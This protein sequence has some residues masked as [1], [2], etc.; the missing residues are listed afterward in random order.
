MFIFKYFF[1]FLDTTRE[2]AK[3]TQNTKIIVGKLVTLKGQMIDQI[4]GY[5]KGVINLTLHKEK[6]SLFTRNNNDILNEKR[7]VEEEV[8]TA[9]VL[10]DRVVQILSKYEADRSS[11]EQEA[12][13]LSKGKH[14]SDKN[15][16]FKAEYDSIPAVLAELDQ[17]MHGIQARIECMTGGHENVRMKLFYL[18]F[19]NLF[20]LN[21][22]LRRS[23][24]TD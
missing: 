19:D 9:R 12:K 22:R 14:P 24:T 3:F 7:T 20:S 21:F 11:K 10:H 18:L 1:Y 15:F 17:Y 6:L 5:Q 23:T 2:H 8:R 13:R 16:P 4:D